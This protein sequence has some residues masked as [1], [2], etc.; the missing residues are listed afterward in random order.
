MEV[1]RGSLCCVEGYFLIR[2][3][4]LCDVEWDWFLSRW[5]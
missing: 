2:V 4:L 3:Y 1:I 5:A